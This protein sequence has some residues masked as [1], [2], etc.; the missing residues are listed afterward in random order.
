MMDLI[1]RYY[2]DDKEFPYEEFVRLFKEDL[3]EENKNREWDIRH[4]ALTDFNNGRDSYINGHE[5]K[6]RT[7]YV[8][9]T[10]KDLL[11]SMIWEG[12]EAEV[13]DAIESLSEEEAEMLVKYIDRAKKDKEKFILKDDKDY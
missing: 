2:R 1:S 13:I 4:Y 7:D 3:E 11:N 9:N 8:Y 6:F 10:A 12:F 5:Y